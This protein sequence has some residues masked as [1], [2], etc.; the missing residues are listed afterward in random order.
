MTVPTALFGRT[1]PVNI[2]RKGWTTRAGSELFDL[3][4]VSTKDGVLTSRLCRRRDMVTT[5]STAIFDLLELI[6]G[7]I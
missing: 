7:D 5:V 3:I 6:G 4:L 2:R 1:S